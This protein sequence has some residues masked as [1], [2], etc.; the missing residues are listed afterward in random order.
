MVMAFHRVPFGGAACDSVAVWDGGPVVYLSSNDPA[1]WFSG[2]PIDYWMTVHGASSPIDMRLRGSGRGHRCCGQRLA[3]VGSRSGSVGRRV[4]LGGVGGGFP[5]VGYLVRMTVV[6][7]SGPSAE[8]TISQT[9]TG[10]MRG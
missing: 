1:T 10:A 7:A 6:A 9:Q 4:S 8:A 2:P 5:A 3:T